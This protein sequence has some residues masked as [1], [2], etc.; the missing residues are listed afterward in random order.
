VHPNAREPFGIAPLEAMA[1]GVPV[2]VPDAGGVLSYANC[3]NAVL[4]AP[5]P[6]AFAAAVRAAIEA[7]ARSR[8]ASALVTARSFDWPRVASQ[9][10]ATYDELVASSGSAQ[11][12][13]AS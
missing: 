9:W 4:A 10:F 2:V 12:R 7:P 8:I 11:T 13:L 6:E 5:T 1:S 3:G